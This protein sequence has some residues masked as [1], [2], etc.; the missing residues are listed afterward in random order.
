MKTRKLSIG[1]IICLGGLSL[2]SQVGAQTVDPNFHIYLA[3]GQSNMEGFANY[4]SDYNTVDKTSLP[5]FQVLGAT[6][7]NDLKRTKDQW[8]PGIAPLFRCGTGLSPVDYFARTLVDSLP[9]TIRIG[10][11][12][13]AVAGTKIEG[14]DP[15]TG[16]AYYDAK[17]NASDSWMYNIAKEYGGDPYARLVAMAKIAQKSGVIKGILLHQGESNAGEAAE[18]WGKK[19]NTTY[20][21]LLKDL[22]LNAKD[23]PLLAGEVA[24]AGGFNVQIDQLPK[25][26]PTAYVISSSGLTIH[27]KD[28]Y[29]LHFSA[30][31]YRTFGKRYAQQMLKLLP[32]TTGVDSRQAQATYA[33]ADFALFDA[34]GKHLASFHTAQA[35]ALDVQWNGVRQKLPVGIYWVKDVSEGSVRK[36][37]NTR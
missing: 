37:V 26:I 14:F 2:A 19:V 10:I 18:V 20:Q 8:S 4:A 1:T 32:K 36:L 31:S 15:T 3:F 5:R 30:E 7:C 21:G 17:A 12:P 28:T 22:G 35:A 34:A 33:G 24:N 16:K 11:V 13:V 29:K 27:A 6:T 23:V 25:T 9:A